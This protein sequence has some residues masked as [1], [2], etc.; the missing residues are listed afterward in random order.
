MGMGDPVSRCPEFDKL[1][2]QVEDVLKI[3]VQ[4][5]TLQL[6]VFRSKKPREFARIDKE[7]ELLVGEKER[8]IGAL[9]QHADEHKCQSV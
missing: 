9:R 5:V 7:L 1:S 3:L 6:E 8:R 2:S 4:T